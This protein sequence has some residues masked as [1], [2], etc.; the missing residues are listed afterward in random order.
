MKRPIAVAVLFSL[1]AVAVRA[2]ATEPSNAYQPR[3]DKDGWEIL[4]DGKDID[5]WEAGGAKGVWIVNADGELYPAKPGPDLATRR[6]YCDFVLEADFKMG[7]KAKANSGV[8]IRVHD[9]RQDVATGMEIQILDNE[10]YK[11]PFNAGNA[12]GI[13]TS[14]CARQWMPTSRSASG[15]TSASPRTTT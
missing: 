4:F 14:W 13:S 2:V 6:R 11:V 1:F 10:D 5:A 7:P 9:R 12:N 3:M 8:F 15:T